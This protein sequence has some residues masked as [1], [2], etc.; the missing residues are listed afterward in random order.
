[1]LT[2]HNWES[3][4][5]HCMQLPSTPLGSNSTKQRRYTGLRL[6]FLQFLGLPGLC[7]GPLRY[8][9]WGTGVGG[10]GI[11]TG[12]TGF[13]IKNANLHRLTQSLLHHDAYGF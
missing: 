5:L 10:T 4:A 1:M 8:R 3:V 11:M 7:T 2:L 9:V 6:L 13:F 12:G